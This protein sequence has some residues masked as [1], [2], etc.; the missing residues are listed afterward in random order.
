MIVIFSIKEDLSTDYVVDWLIKLK[1]KFVRLNLSINYCTHITISNINEEI[2][3]VIGNKIALKLSEISSIWFRR[4]GLNLDFKFLDIDSTVLNLYQKEL[5]LIADY[6]L[7]SFNKIDGNIGTINYSVNKIEVLSIAREVGL[8]I[9]DSLISSKK[10]SLVEFFNKHNKD[11]ITKSL[12]QIATIN[13]LSTGYG[14]PTCKVDE[15]DL[16]NMENEFFYTFFQ[17]NVA[18]QYEVRVFYIKNEF[19]SIAIFSQQN[20]RSKIDNRLGNINDIRC[21]PYQI[22]PELERIITRLMKRLNLNSG[23]LDFIY[24]PDKKFVF[25][26]VNPV[27][28][29]GYVSRI[30]NY[31][32]H[33]KISEFL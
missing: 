21:T 4:G 13:N 28:Q 23:S 32:L 2:N 15:K 19:Y 1:K 12:D 3:L 25:L 24:T 30:G 16:I 7:F 5:K 27:G 29:F 11:I 17:E 33:K 31:Y 8:N 22:P 26:E 6:I 14:M 18:K 20:D 9:P 10:N